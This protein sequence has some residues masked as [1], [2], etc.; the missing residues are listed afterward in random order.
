MGKTRC[1][2]C[3]KEFQQKDGIYM[4]KIWS[5]H[6]IILDSWFV[7]SN[8][9]LEAF[10][11]RVEAVAA[12]SS[13]ELLSNLSFA[14]PILIKQTLLS[15]LSERQ[16]SYEA[17]LQQ[18]VFEV[19]LAPLEEIDRTPRNNQLWNKLQKIR[20]YVELKHIPNLIK[21]RRYEE[22]AKFYEKQGMYEEAGKLRD[23]DREVIIKKTEITVDLNSLLRQIAESGIVAVYRCP[24][25]G[26]K[27]KIG[28]ETAM[29]SLRTCEHCGSEIATM[30][31]ADFL[32]TV[33]S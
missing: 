3:G 7:C 12:N 33:L 22:A 19:N 24:H 16:L 9:C 28:K 6:R 30:D 21:A 23:K 29:S 18:A 25:C 26:G 13:L 10:Y 20:D 11:Y 14:V 27:L 8:Y 5:P 31:M 17:R 1:K 32:K 2:I 15:P 4:F